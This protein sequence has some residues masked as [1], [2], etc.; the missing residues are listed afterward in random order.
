MPGGFTVKAGLKREANP[1]SR[2]WPTPIETVTQL[3]P[4]RSSSV[5]PT[6]DQAGVITV[7][8]QGTTSPPRILSQYLVGDISV[9]M[10]YTGLE[11]LLVCGL[12]F[13]APSLPEE[14]DTG[15]YRHLFEIDGVLSQ[16]VFLSDEGWLADDGLVVD[17]YK[18]RRVTYVVD[19]TAA[20]WEAQSVMV[21]SLIFQAN[22]AE[23]TL[24]ASIQ[25]Y[26][27]ELFGQVNDLV[28][29]SCPY[30]PVVFTSAVLYL[31]DTAPVPVFSDDLL[32]FQVTVQHGLNVIQTVDSG[33]KIAEP[34]KSGATVVSGSL[35]FPFYSASSDA[36]RFW[37]D[38]GAS[39]Y[40]VL[41]F[42]GPEIG[43][44][45]YDHTLRLYMPNLVVVS[46]NSDVTGP[47]QL[48]H[49][50]SFVC[51]PGDTPEGFPANIK[52]GAFMIEITNSNAS[53]ALLT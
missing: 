11:E 46:H 33:L 4:L 35:A 36:L 17:T 10:S 32:G 38:N 20:L 42:I 9:G 25:G 43:A 52:N 28:G 16:Q 53:H 40:A 39:L 2:T 49:T 48:Q 3:L 41:E 47:E 5:G 51:S 12:G 8:S 31:S 1:V 6:T 34:R 21:D 15:V 19:K 14:L 44:T 23:V 45:G 30:T 22:G 29:L 7:S 37:A 27:I 24:T 50:F 13:M 26:A 18:N